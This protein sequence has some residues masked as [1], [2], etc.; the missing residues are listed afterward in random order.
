MWAYAGAACRRVHPATVLAGWS[1]RWFSSSAWSS[2]SIWFNPSAWSSPSSWSSP[3]V[4]SYFSDGSAPRISTRQNPSSANSS[5]LQLIHCFL[6][7][8]YHIHVPSL[9]P[10]DHLSTQPLSASQPN[11]HPTA[12][13][14]PACLLRLRL[15]PSPVCHTSPLLNKY[16]LVN[17]RDR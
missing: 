4:W 7:S 8:L 14:L 5:L 1:P 13:P 6:V 12:H 11:D 10:L 9:R 15:I 17:F 3:L 16:R 2:S